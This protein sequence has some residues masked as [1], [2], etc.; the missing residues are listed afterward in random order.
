MQMY[1]KLFIL[2]HKTGIM[3]DNDININNY[4][5]QTSP[6]KAFLLALVPLW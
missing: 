5:P 6:A 3:C 1:E 4:A 2:P